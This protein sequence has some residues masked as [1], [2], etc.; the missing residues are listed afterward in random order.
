MS[1]LCVALAALGVGCGDDGADSLED[2]LP[3]IP[4]PTG[5][6]QAVWAGAI[7]TSNT[8]DLIDGPAT[9][10]MV[11]DF[12]MRNAAG[13]YVIQSPTR[14][15]G[16]IPQG[17]NL[18]DAVA[19][20]ADGN[21]VSEDHFGELS[22][23]YLLGRTCE[24]NEIEVLQDGSGGGAAVVRA[25]GV[26]GN[27]DFINLRG[28]GILNI[29]LDLD[30]DIPDEVECATT[31][32][33]EPGSATLNVHWTMYNPGED[34]IV[35]PFGSL[36]DTGGENESWAP[37]RGF[38]RLG[39]EAITSAGEPAPIEYAV[40]Q[41]PGAAYG[42]L[43]RHEV[44][45]TNSTFLVA[46]VSIV[47]YGAE[48][49]LDILNPDAFY[50]DLPAGGGLTHRVDVSVGSDAADAEEQFRI[51]RDEA[52]AEISGTTQ[53]QAAA[54]PVAARVG[55]YSDENGNGQ[56]DEGDLIRS[57]M[58]ADADGSYSGMVPPGNY[59]AR[60]EVKNVSRSDAKA[61]AL[62]DSGMSGLTL[63]LPDPVY[64]DF[65]ITDDATGNTIPGKI[66][67]IGQHPAYPDSNVFEIYDRK[68]G[69]VDIKWSIRG[70]TT[71]M[72]DGADARLALPAGGTYKVI[73]SR[74]TEWSVDA[75]VVSP[76]AGDPVGQLDFTLR[77]V[78]DTPGYISSEY[79]V[80][81][82]GSPDSP[83][84]FDKRIATMVADGVEVF[85]STEHDY[86]ADLGPLITSMGLERHVASIPGIE[87]TPF[88]YGHFNAWPITP[89][90]TQPNNGAID[91]ARGAGE[92]YAMIPGEIYDAMRAAGAELVQVNHPRSVSGITDFQQAFDRAGLVFDYERR[93]IDGDLLKAPVPNEWMRLPDVSLWDDSFNA[94]EVWNGFDMEDSN[95]D[96][97]RE[98]ARLDAVMR[99]WFNFT[100]FGMQIVPIGSS[101]T[102]TAI[103]DPAGMPRT[104][105]RVADDSPDAIANGNAVGDILDTL[106]GNNVPIDVIV[107]NGPHVEVTVEGDDGGSA[108]GRTFDMSGPGEVTFNIRIVSPDWAQFDTIELFANNTQDI[109]DNTTALHPVACATSRALDSM[110]VNDVCM[111]AATA[112][113]VVSVDLVDAGNGFLRYE[114]TVSFTVSASDVVN[115]EGATGTDAW[116]VARVRGSR[117]VFPILFDDAMTEDNVDTL[118]SGTQQQID[119]ILDGVG[120]PAT[121]FTSPIFVDFDGGGYTA[122]FEP[123]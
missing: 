38:E 27:N 73:V 85:A 82:V 96:G 88:T 51:G 29:P 45:A 13:R 70:T 54:T 5:D 92:G 117:A 80:H 78:A 98:I 112:P 43:P 119:A 55:L 46:G 84:G 15:I 41:G 8:E 89:D 53:W 49:L 104:Y 120:V 114:A 58:D 91:W 11:G 111:T 17:G 107:T 115:R 1:L 108:L 69:L 34:D 14:V 4:Q 28:I 118:V 42:I 32:V 57:Y 7:T 76:I 79:H 93:S 12:Y 83:V 40:Y 63:D 90:T 94:L 19:V 21:D 122:I 30:P 101:D 105:V 97:V 74:G 50:L 20:D 10:G 44:E 121:A 64:F 31:Y 47:L 110:A 56:I 86:V 113:V 3:E 35:G 72:G 23:V 67:I 99:D 37:T 116:F 18:V 71:D 52:L 103:K 65:D 109:D 123:Q 102:H 60:A 62:G 22:M 68:A 59:L 100:S 25:T 75:A 39:I 26:S 95:D 61:V 6:A 66:S 33:L 77:R 48:N 106:T 9:S 81:S 2:F 87:V 24:H 16:V 36:N